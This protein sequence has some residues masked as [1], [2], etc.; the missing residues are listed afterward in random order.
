ML[1]REHKKILSQTHSNKSEVMSKA[2]ES[3][4]RI[5][6]HNIFEGLDNKQLLDHQTLKKATHK[7]I[8]GSC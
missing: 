4:T 2:T 3:K 7:D 5:G 1:R 6:D 8:F